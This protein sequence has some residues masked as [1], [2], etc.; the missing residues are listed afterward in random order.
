MAVVGVWGLVSDAYIASTTACLF[1]YI[2]FHPLILQAQSLRYFPITMDASFIAIPVGY[3]TIALQLSIVPFLTYVVC[4]LSAESQ[5]RRGKEV[6]A[7][8]IQYSYLMRMYNT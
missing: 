7:H 8:L 6:S 2:Y 1:A 5:L 3:M 4:G